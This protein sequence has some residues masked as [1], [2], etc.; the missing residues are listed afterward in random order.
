MIHCGHEIEGRLEFD[1]V[2]SRVGG[3]ELMPFARR[4]E[5]EAAGPD[6]ERAGVVLY[7]AGAFL[8]EIEM[9]RRNGTRW[10][11]PMDVPRR[12]RARRVRHA[13]D[14]QIPRA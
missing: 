13:A 1:V 10:R 8:D 5:H 12:M 11:R 2:E 6:S 9:L 4:D 7:F 3:D 14:L